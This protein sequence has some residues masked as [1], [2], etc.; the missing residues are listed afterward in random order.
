[1][2]VD[3][4]LYHPKWG[5]IRLLIK[6]RAGNCCEHCKA[7][8]GTLHVHLADGQTGVPATRP[9][10]G[11][12]ARSAQAAGL[13]LVLIQCGV[14][15]LDQDR[16]NNRFSNLAFLCRGCHLKYDMPYNKGKIQM[17][18]RYGKRKGQIGLF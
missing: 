1:M 7:E 14:A 3:Y 15:H 11:Q 13:R 16:A 2:P 17:T 5:L 10:Q 6:R 9:I 12:A 8:N 18:R 4:K